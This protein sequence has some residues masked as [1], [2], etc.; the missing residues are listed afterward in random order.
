MT[1][2]ETKLNNETS[3]FDSTRPGFAQRLLSSIADGVVAVDVAGNVNYLNSVGETLTDWSLAEARGR[4]VEEVLPLINEN[5]R[6]PVVNPIRT[7]LKTREAVGLANHN[8]L[9][10][11]DGVEI[12]IDDSASPIE[13]ATGELTG[14]VLIFRSIAE[15]AD[16]EE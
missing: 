2:D 12:P 1:R 15:Q 13:T 5:S 7:V 16:H 6:E 3:I 8:C 4:A 9:I 14:A 10:R 11:R